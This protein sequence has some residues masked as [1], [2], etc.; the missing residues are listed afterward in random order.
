[1]A[2][3]IRRKDDD[4][5]AGVHHQAEVALQAQDLD[6]PEEARAKSHALEEGLGHEVDLPQRTA[7][8]SLLKSNSAHNQRNSENILVRSIIHPKDLFKFE[9]G[10]CRP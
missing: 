9:S 4:G 1:M 2:T 7:D 10:S 6:H 5:L 3:E 8:T